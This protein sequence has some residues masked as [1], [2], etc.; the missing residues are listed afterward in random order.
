M[1]LMLET[2]AQVLFE[3]RGGFRR[4]FRPLRYGP[5]VFGDPLHP[6]GAGKFGAGANMSFDVELVRRLG[7]FDEALDTGRSLPG[8]GDLDM[9]YRVLRSGR[10]LVYEPQSTVYHEHRRDLA[11]LKRQY[12]TW[13][14]GFFAFIEKTM[15][16]DPNMRP[17]L[18]RVTLWWLVNQASLACNSL[19]GREATPLPMILGELSGG[20][21][22]LAGEYDRSLRRI[23]KIRRAST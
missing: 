4:G 13:G 6:C 16:N 5:K 10:F 14:L 17:A 1:P 23:G 22:G 12:Y 19:A 20:I 21:K 15:R 7:G 9:F 3:L 8:G 2:E 18:Y 11:E